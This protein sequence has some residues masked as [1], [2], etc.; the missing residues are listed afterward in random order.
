MATPGHEVERDMETAGDCG[1][2]LIE[3]GNIGGLSFLTLFAPPTPR[4]VMLAG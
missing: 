2:Q 1:K 3:S 4:M